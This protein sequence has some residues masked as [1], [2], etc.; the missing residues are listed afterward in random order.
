MS[1]GIEN[2]IQDIREDARK[3]KTGIGEIKTQVSGLEKKLTRAVCAAA[4]VGAAA[5]AFVAGL[6]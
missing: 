5:G 1:D 4:L 3:I 2:K 6:L